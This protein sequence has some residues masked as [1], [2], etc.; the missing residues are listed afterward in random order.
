MIGPDHHRLKVN[1]VASDKI[2]LD[3][4]LIIFFQVM[5]VLSLGPFWID[6]SQLGFH[7]SQLRVMV[8]FVKIFVD[9][10]VILP[11]LLF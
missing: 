4:K 7:G 9:K 11:L 8:A 1:F 2:G 6:L 10:P 3:I 5:M